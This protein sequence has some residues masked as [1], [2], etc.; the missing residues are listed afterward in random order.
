MSDEDLLLDHARRYFAQAGQSSDMR[1]M[2]M[3]AELGLEFIRLAQPGG[4]A[5]ARP[6]TDKGDS[7][8]AEGC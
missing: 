6:G 7:S 3:L 2:R 1:K 5:P 8:S 4:Y